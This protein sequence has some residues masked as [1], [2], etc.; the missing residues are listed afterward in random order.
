MIELRGISKSY[1]TAANEVRALDGV[2][3]H[4]GLG[5]AVCIV[6]KSGSGKTTLLDIVATLLKPTAGRYLFEGEDV[7]QL[8][9]RALAQLRNR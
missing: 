3:I 4:I 7:S 9:E 2:D 1:S 8:S 5:E 6:G